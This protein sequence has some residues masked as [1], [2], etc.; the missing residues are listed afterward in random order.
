VP[1]L[2]LC[3]FALVPEQDPGTVLFQDDFSGPDLNIHWLFYGDPLPRVEDSSGV[4]PPCFNNNG[5]SM[6]GSGVISRETF[7]ITAGLCVE[8]D[9]FMNCCERGTWVTASLGMVSPEFRE[10]YASESDL[11]IAKLDLS[12]SGELDWACPH[13]QTVLNMNGRNGEDLKYSVFRIHQNHLMNR[14]VR[15]RLQINSDLTVSYFIEDSLYMTS[16]FP[17]PER[18]SHIRVRLGNRSSNWGIALHDNL[19]V[20]IS[21]E[22]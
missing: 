4:P 9:M 3:T 11:I 18:L 16:P 6:G 13:R 8:C 7:P 10:G 20:F 15:C 14:W 22:I 2:L 12:Y 17:I 19:E 5:D 21:E 1:V